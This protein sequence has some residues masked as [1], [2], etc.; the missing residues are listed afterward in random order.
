MPQNARLSLRGEYES[1]TVSRSR[2]GSAPEYETVAYGQR[3]GAQ[4][5]PS[6]R[7]LDAIWRQNCKF[8][9]LAITK[10]TSSGKGGKKEEAARSIIASVRSLSL[11]AFLR[12]P[13]SRAFWPSPLPQPFLRILRP[14]GSH[15]SATERGQGGKRLRGKY[16]SA[17]VSRSKKGSAPECETVAEGQIRKHNSLTF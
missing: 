11:G 2:G 4:S 10:K 12:R 14:R 6:K 7:G 17:T 1:T 9:V 15:C 3:E 16:E 13:C 8:H 5:G